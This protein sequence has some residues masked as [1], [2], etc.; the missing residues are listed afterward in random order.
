MDALTYGA[1]R[2]APFASRLDAERWFQLIADQVGGLDETASWEDARHVLRSGAES[3]DLAWAV[4]AVT[5]YLDSQSVD[6]IQVLW[7]LADSDHRD[8]YVAASCAA[9][10]AEE[11]AA[12]GAT[13]G[14]AADAAYGDAYAGGSV[15]GSETGQADTVPFDEGVWYEYLQRWQGQWDGTDEAWQP[16]RESFVYWAPDGTRDAARQL[17]EQAEASDR[18]AALAPYGIVAATPAEPAGPADALVE[19]AAQ[20]TAAADRAADAPAAGAGSAEADVG[21]SGIP[22]ADEVIG[23]LLQDR[24]ELAALGAERLQELYAEV[25]AELDAAEASARE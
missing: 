17:L 4:E 3:S 6:P 20:E 15:S 2:S 1:V 18:A 13:A 24:P 23:G 22:E 8:E 7:E 5:E 10:E 21:T 11:A 19:T 9:A 16:F 12:G 25:I 14:G